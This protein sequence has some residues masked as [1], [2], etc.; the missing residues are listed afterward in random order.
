MYSYASQREID[1]GVNEESEKN[2]RKEA[3]R[4]GRGWK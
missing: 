2:D 3:K 4:G 1:R